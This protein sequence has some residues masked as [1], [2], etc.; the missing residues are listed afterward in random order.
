MFFIP[1]GSC[2]STTGRGLVFRNASMSQSC[3]SMQDLL[4]DK[5][6]IT[7]VFFNLSS[8]YHIGNVCPITRSNNFNTF[9][10]TEK[11]KENQFIQAKC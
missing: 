1:T 9:T 10:C 5:V 6:G 8:V 11:R 3:Q 2:A 7:P 4:Q